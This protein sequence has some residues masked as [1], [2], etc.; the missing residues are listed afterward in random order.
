MS[1]SD[2]ENYAH[3]GKCV[4]IEVSFQS[5]PVFKGE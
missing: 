3:E 4:Y 2:F 1:Q 5:F